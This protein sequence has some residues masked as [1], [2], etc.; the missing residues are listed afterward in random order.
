ML[1]KRY[2]R[3]FNTP[4]QESLSKKVAALE[5]AEAALILVIW[6]GCYFRYFINLFKVWRSCGYTK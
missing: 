6:Y 2:P 1:T 4:N 3:Y 5:H